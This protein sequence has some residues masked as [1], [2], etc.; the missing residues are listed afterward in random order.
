MISLLMACMLV[1][2]LGAYAQDAKETAAQESAMPGNQSEISSE[3]LTQILTDLKKRLVINDQGA[4]FKYSVGLDYGQN[5]YNLTW[6]LDSQV[7]EVRYGDD[8]NIYAY[9]YTPKAQPYREG[10]LKKLPQYSKSEAETI[11]KDFTM[12]AFPVAVLMRASFIIVP[13]DFCSC[14]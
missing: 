3:K 7:Q 13:N 14:T 1:N 12:K 2:P 8:K 5:Y 4:D 6:T 11:A 9:S 10:E